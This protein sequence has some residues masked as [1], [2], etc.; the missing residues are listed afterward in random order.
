MTKE[1]L[2]LNKLLN[3]LWDIRK[4]PYPIHDYKF[5]SSK[6]LS[7]IY[8]ESLNDIEFWHAHLSLLGLSSNWNFDFYS[9]SEDNCANET[10]K[11]IKKYINRLE[12]QNKKTDNK[13]FNRHINWENWLINYKKQHVDS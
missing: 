6:Y 9:Y 5:K 11:V 1:D 4:K 10:Y 13:T 12:R 2:K 3:D 8:F 7:Y